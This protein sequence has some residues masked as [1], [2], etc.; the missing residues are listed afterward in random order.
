MGTRKILET[1]RTHPP[2]WHWTLPPGDPVV[3]Y[4]GGLDSLSALREILEKEGF[5]VGYGKEAGFDTGDNYVRVW[6]EGNI[7]GL[8]IAAPTIV[9]LSK[10]PNHVRMRVFEHEEILWAYSP[11]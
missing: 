8:T 1:H 2:A 9:T 6:R 5:G 10:Q 11:A 4:D 3:Y 7:A